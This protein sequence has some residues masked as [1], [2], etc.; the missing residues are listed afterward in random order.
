MHKMDIVSRCSNLE[1][2][3]RENYVCHP[4]FWFD[5]GSVVLRVQDHLFKVHRSFL[6]RH[7]SFFA[8]HQYITKTSEDNREDGDM[9]CDYIMIGHERRVLVQDVEILLEHLYHDVWV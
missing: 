8:Q 6:S 9:D 4:T 7:S 3:P 1:G 5:D 2:S